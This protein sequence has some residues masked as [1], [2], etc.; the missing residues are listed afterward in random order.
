MAQLLEP[1]LQRHF[2]DPGE[3]ADIPDG[4]VCSVQTVRVSGQKE[5]RIIESLEPVLNQHRLVIHPDIAKDEIL[6][7]QWTRVTRQRGSLDHDDRIEALAMAVRSWREEMA[8]D[9]ER[10]AERSRQRIIDDELR[11]LRRQDN[12]TSWIRRR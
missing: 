3:E 7:H 1:V 11:K 4:W 12:G 6:Q 10:A 5:I 9:P 8:A 2:S